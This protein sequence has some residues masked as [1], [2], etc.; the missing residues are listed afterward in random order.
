MK[1]PHAVALGRLGGKAGTGVAKARTTE[2]ARKAGK[3]S[4]ETRRARAELNQQQKDRRD[5]RP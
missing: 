5:E 1:N 3:A 4:G 2:Q